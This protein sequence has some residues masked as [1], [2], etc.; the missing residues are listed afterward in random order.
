LGATLNSELVLQGVKKMKQ[1]LSKIAVGLLAA[2]TFA[3]SAGATTQAL[4]LDSNG[5]GS[6]SASVNGSFND[7][8]TFSV[9]SLELGSAIAMASTSVSLHY[10]IPSGFT[11]VYPIITTFQI[12]DSSNNVVSLQSDLS[13]S[14]QLTGQSF[15]AQTEFTG[16]K[17]G[18]YSLEIA[19]TSTTAGTYGGTFALSTI[20]APVPEPETY[21]MMLAGLGLMAAIARRRKQKTAIV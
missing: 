10:N 17:A 6:F 12:L 16:L 7:Y 20:A 8:W 18:S 21:A 2:L 14:Y 11:L 3:G 1:I 4:T 15:L 9:P 13:Q 5:T 19:G